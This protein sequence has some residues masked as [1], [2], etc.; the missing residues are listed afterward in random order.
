MKVKLKKCPFCKSKAFV[1]ID[2]GEGYSFYSIGCS[3]NECLISCRTRW[4]SDLDKLVIQWNKR[5]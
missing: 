3:S 2:K 5:G 4:D 1:G